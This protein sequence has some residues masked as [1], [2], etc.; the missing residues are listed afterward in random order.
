MNYLF[1]RHWFVKIIYKD[2]EVRM[3]PLTTSLL[4]SIVANNKNKSKG[5]LPELGK[6]LILSSVDKISSIRIP[7]KD[8]VWA[9][10]FDGIVE[11]DEETDHICSGKSVWEFGTNNDSL[12]KINADYAKRNADPLG[13]D[14][15]TTV[16][17]L[18]VPKIWSYSQSISE[19]ENEHRGEWAKVHIIDA[20]ELCD[21]INSIPSVCCWL[22]ENYYNQEMLTFTSVSKAWEHFSKKTMPQLSK[23]LFLLGREMETELLN[24]RS[25]NPI[26][27][28]QSSSHV[29]AIGFVIASVMLHKEHKET[30]IVVEDE[31]TFRQLN[32]IVKNQTFIFTFHYDGDV[33]LERNNSVILCFSDVDISIKPDIRLNKI[34]KKDYENALKIMGLTEIDVSRLSKFTDRNIT[35]LLRKIPGNVNITKPQWADVSDMSYLI[36]LLFMRKINRDND[37]DRSIVE[38]FGIAYK[39]FENKINTLIKLEDRPV[40]AVERYFSI[41]S[42]EDVWSYFHFSTAD[43]CYETLIDLVLSVFQHINEKA[44]SQ[45]FDS[46]AL[47]SIDRRLLSNLLTNLVYF[48]SISE[49][50]K[51]RVARDVKTI[52]NEMFEINCRNALLAVLPVLANAAPSVVM[53]FINNNLDK[54]G[55]IDLLFENQNYAG[56]YCKILWT[57]ETLLKYDE[58]KFDAIT[59]LE[60]LY[61]R[62]YTYKISNNPKD[63]LLNSLCLWNT[64]TALLLEDKEKIILK[65][66]DD[67]PIQMSIFALDLL[68]KNNYSRSIS[69]EEFKSDV[70]NDHAITYG[71]IFNVVNS[72]IPKIADIIIERKSTEVLLEFIKAYRLIKLET[73]HNLIDRIMNDEYESNELQKVYFNTLLQIKRCETMYRYEKSDIYIKYIEVFKKLSDKIQSPDLIVRYSS[74]FQSWWDCPLLENDDLEEDIDYEKESQRKFEYRQNIYNE[75]KNT[76]GQ[77]TYCKLL[78]V[79]SDDPSWGRFLLRVDKTIDKKQ[80]CDACISL[81]KYQILLC[82]LDSIDRAEFEKIFVTYNENLK[83]KLLPHINRVDILDL[84]LC[85]DQEK[86]Y[87]GHKTM[88]QYDCVTYQK[89]LQYNP[90]GLILYYARDDISNENIDD[91]IQVLR[92]LSELNVDT[93]QVQ[94]GSYY[95]EKLFNKLDATQYS[96]E[97]AKLEFDFYDRHQIEDFLEG[98]KKYYFYNPNVIVD[99]LNIESTQFTMYF[100][101]AHNYSLPMIAYT[102]Y[103]KFQFFFDSIITNSNDKGYAYGIAGQILGRS[104]DGADKIFPHEF[105]RKLIEKYANEQLNRDFVIGRSNINGMQM[106]IV[107]DGS[108]QIAIAEKLKNDANSIALLY[109]ITA[110]LLRKL[111]EMHIKEASE[112]RVWS[113][114]G[115]D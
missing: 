82:I 94:N 18:V 88:Y 58:T 41:I 112:D 35:I 115:F 53:D 12:S 30:F 97:I 43:S 99:A 102:D 40:K 80:L 107:G 21:W 54:G 33:C 76:H 55:F 13:V 72:V 16:F 11:C 52:L 32:R 48:A 103:D 46:I 98:M 27:R 114:I 106:R 45:Q 86:A 2:R 49:T 95:I 29:D 83:I 42:Y 7:S 38:L 8:D 59:A 6:R 108:D 109:P 89:L 24:A 34:S 79:M 100:D 91:I 62:G 70:H 10:G 113:E 111:S 64:N 65:F 56:E 5:M 110:Q 20:S 4:E 78:T 15:A 104:I 44:V 50:D 77:N 57:L 96:T 92:R 68:E 84:L 26:T 66:L 105:T 61:L 69:L 47:D 1:G 81:S 36:P 63:S 17:Y 90:I 85:E 74:F 22:F 39:E 19:W 25:G 87:W 14:K 3:K 31:V 101:L 37:I 93:R 67:E 23:E 71:G 51:L 73:Y 60:K 75:L 9:P 28:V